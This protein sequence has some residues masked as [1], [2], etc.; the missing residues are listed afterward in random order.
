MVPVLSDF[1]QVVP[2]TGSEKIVE[3]GSA[4][5]GIQYKLYLKRI[6]YFKN[7][8]VTL[9]NYLAVYNSGYTV[10]QVWLQAQILST[11]LYRGKFPFRSSSTLPQYKFVVTRC[12]GI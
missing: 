3:V 4:Y 10:R 2:G 6:R 12:N 1:F 7:K 8:P 11:S 9:Q 5:Y